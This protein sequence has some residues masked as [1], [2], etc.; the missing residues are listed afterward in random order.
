MHV[1][2]KVIFCENADPHTSEES[3][4][5]TYRRME[6]NNKDLLVTL[7]IPSKTGGLF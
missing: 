4:N 2:F 3:F 7:P 1:F 6:G 5:E